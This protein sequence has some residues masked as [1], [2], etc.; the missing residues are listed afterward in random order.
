M[1]IYYFAWTKQLKKNNFGGIEPSEMK[2]EMNV[3][4]CV[5][6]YLARADRGGLECKYKYVHMYKCIFWFESEFLQTVEKTKYTIKNLKHCYYEIFF[7][8]K[9]TIV[10]KKY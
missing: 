6:I 4:I 2:L 8:N 9:E 5:Y 3:Y 1:H 10:S 7:L